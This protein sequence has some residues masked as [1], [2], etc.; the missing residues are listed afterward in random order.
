[1]AVR[2]R[3]VEDKSTYSN[4]IKSDHDNDFNFV[5]SEYGYSIQACLVDCLYTNI[6]EQCGCVENRQE[7]APDTR[8]Y[9][10]YPNCRLE[11]I[12][13]VIKEYNRAESCNCGS[14]CE[15]RVYEAGTSYSRVPA[16]YLVQSLAD[17]Y[18][19]SYA[20][21]PTLQT[22][23]EQNIIAVNVYFE[24]LNVEL[25]VTDDAYGVVALLSDIG[26]C[27]VGSG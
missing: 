8:R 15:Y 27:R 10:E 13:C 3:R 16:E 11:D 22:F 5:S 23:Y 1:M 14:A 6:A 12:C 20:D 21:L 17:D 19:F 18:N 25:Q 26:I 24:S 2:E 9:A 4:C 7:Y